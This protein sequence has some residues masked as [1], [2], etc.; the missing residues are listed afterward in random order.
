MA[1]FFDQFDTPPPPDGYQLVN[2]AGKGDYGASGN[3]FDQFDAAPQTARPGTFDDLIPKQQQGNSIASFRAQYPQYSD[4]SDG[5]LADSVYNKFYSDMPR[6]QFNAKIGMRTPVTDPGLLAQLNGS[7]GPTPVTDPTILAQLNGNGTPDTLTDVAK[8]GA[9]GLAEGA[10]G[11]A[12]L[13]GN[14]STLL[15]KGIDYGLNKLGVDTPQSYSNPTGTD[16]I[17][18]GIEGLTGP[19]YQPQTTAGKYAQTIGEFAPAAI[20]GP[21]S[22]ATRLLT[23]VAV[24]AVASEAAGEAAQGTGFEPVA[25]IGS[26]LIG[27]AA[28][29]KLAN[30]TRTAPAAIPAVED[31]ENAKTAA[32][33][34][35]EIAAVQINPTA[36]SDLSDNLHQTLLAGKVDKF[37]APTV[38]G[39]VDRLA[40]PRFGQ[41][42]TID[43]L[44]LARRSLS[45]VPPN[46][47]RAAG[48]VRKGIDDYLGNIPQADLLAGDATAA[49]A[50]LLEARGNTAA[51]KRSQEVTNAMGRADTQAG[52]T[53]SGNNIENATR[54]QLKTILNQKT[55]VARTQGFQDYTPEEIAALR[56]AVVGTPFGNLVRSAGKHLGGGGG[57]GAFVTGV[58]G[59][60]AAHE[61]GADF[62]PSLAAGVG[63][64]ALGHSLG[65]WGNRMAVSRAN[66]VDQLLRSRSPLGAPI[67]AANA[68]LPRAAN[69]ILS[70]LISGQLTIPQLLSGGA[71]V[72]A[73]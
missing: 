1:N 16:A 49:N 71:N 40:A 37:V 7:S 55:G 52:A 6:D 8:S 35:P 24:P 66:A 26:A 18:K 13:P 10:I 19:F 44:D 72:P 4:M 65:A 47:I 20:G 12:G 68:Q 34:S 30:L 61:A 63:S 21:E 69:P 48:I 64:A 9:T 53:Y 27:G 51:M 31:L 15:N 42:G 17:Q 36:L 67:A 46:E 39:I 14:M 33:Q 2:R 43:D 73:Q 29:A 32:Y 59:A 28:G 38:S 62:W 11:L 58:S 60:V 57:A 23:R 41:T 25:R 5:Q 50:K 56:N 22:L 45:D 54:Q 70:A 3:Y